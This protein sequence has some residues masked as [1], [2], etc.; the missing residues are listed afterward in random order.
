MAELGIIEPSKSPWA[1]PLVTVRKKD[2][3]LRLCGDYRRLNQVT[4]GDSYCMPRPDELL[5]RMG[6]A[7]FITTLD[8][9]KCYYQVPMSQKDREKTAFMTP[10]GKYQ[11][12]RQRH[13]RGWSTNY[14]MARANT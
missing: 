8:K 4:E 6:K 13:S 14:S 11:K 1:S 9:L 10:L 5:D 3:R 7:R 12:M 2:G